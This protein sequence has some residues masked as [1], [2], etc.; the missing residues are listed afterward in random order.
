MQQRRE[1]IA[2]CEAIIRER[3]RALLEAY[4]RA[5]VRFDARQNP[6]IGG[7]QAAAQS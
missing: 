1:E 7:C 3:A 4:R 5:T 2:K 6:E